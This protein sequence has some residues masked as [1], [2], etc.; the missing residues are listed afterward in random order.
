MPAILIS[1]LAGLI[2]G[3][4]IGG[5]LSALTTTQWL[6]MAEGIAADLEPEA[7]K[8]LGLQHQSLGAMVEAIGKGLSAELASKAAQNWFSANADA[9]MREQPGMGEH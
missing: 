8:L 6:T 2:N 5:L 9:A 7:A 3:G 1:L 4:S